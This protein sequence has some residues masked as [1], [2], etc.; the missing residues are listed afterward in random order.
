MISVCIPVFNFDVTDLV[1]ALLLQLEA[2]SEIVLIDDASTER[3]QQINRNLTSDKVKLIE[4]EENVG[5][6]KIRNL[7]LEYANNPYLVFL[8]CDAK[9]ISENYLHNYR[10]LLNNDVQVVCGGSVNRSEEHHV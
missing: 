5:R 2:T 9:I 7:F 4:L 10:M 8:D 1:N 6:A 3:F